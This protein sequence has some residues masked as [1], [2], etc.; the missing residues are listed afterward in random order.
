MWHCDFFQGLQVE[1][2]LMEWE[3]T[4]YPQ[5]QLTLASKEP[6][7]RLWKTALNFTNKHDEWINGKNYVFIADLVLTSSFVLKNKQI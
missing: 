2:G 5:I 1:E 4:Q 7:D 3:V 6:F